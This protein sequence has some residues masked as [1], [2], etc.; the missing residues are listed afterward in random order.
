MKNILHVP[1]GYSYCSFRVAVTHRKF[2]FFILVILNAFI[3]FRIKFPLAR[4]EKGVYYAYMNTLQALGRGMRCCAHSALLQP[5]V[6]RALRLMLA[7]S[8]TIFK[9]APS[10]SVLCTA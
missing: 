4:F 2:C 8:C 9:V 3:L 5:R 1:L 10:V 7:L 6:V